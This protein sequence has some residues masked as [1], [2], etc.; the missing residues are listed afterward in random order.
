MIWLDHSAE[1]AAAA[2]A[3]VVCQEVKGYR[4]A[5][6]RGFAEARGRY[7][8]MGDGDQ[9]YDFGALPEFVHVLEEGLIR[10]WGAVSADVRPY[11]DT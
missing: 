2:S 3:R 10:S 5:L 6:K 8:I 4:S 1:L 11:Q 7:I 9:T